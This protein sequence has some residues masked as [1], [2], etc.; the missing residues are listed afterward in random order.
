MKL[1]ETKQLLESQFETVEITAVPP[2][3]DIKCF[4]LR[5][6]DAKV[7]FSTKT[8][9][10]RDAKTL[11]EGTK[12]ALTTT[13][14]SEVNFFDTP[15]ET[16]IPQHLDMQTLKAFW[17]RPKS[18]KMKLKHAKQILNEIFDVVNIY[19]TEDGIDVHCTLPLKGNPHIESELEG[20]VHY[21]SETNETVLDGV[22]E[23]LK[24]YRGK[25]SPCCVEFSTDKHAYNKLYVSGKPVP[26]LVSKGL[27]T[28][29]FFASQKE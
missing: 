2:K 10:I 12:R 22:I 27:L 4:G 1:A 3:W 23:V 21:K 11:L 24:Q 15:P 13:R 5:R 8:V 16:Q 17:T 28:D 20:T 26:T 6:S 25:R 18:K 14:A 29:T 9:H 19:K 7:R